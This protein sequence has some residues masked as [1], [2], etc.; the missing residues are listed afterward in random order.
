MVPTIES[1]VYK[2]QM[3]IKGWFL[4]RWTTCSIGPS[5]EDPSIRYPLSEVNEADRND[6]FLSFVII[7]RFRDI[8]RTCNG[9]IGAM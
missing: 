2:D 7:Q 1:L 9:I 5:T 3:M 8:K 6:I 4:S